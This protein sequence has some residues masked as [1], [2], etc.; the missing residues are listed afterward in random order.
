V[1][2]SLDKGTQLAWPAL[3]PERRTGSEIDAERDAL[4]GEL[5]ASNLENLGRFDF[6]GAMHGTA[7]GGSYVT[8]G[9][10]AVLRAADC[11]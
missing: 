4:A 7:P 10:I 1:T 5:A 8:D 9:Q 11:G 3:R 2:A 6:A